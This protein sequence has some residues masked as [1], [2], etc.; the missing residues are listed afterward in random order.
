MVNKEGQ[1][2]NL[3]QII[4]T[5]LPPNQIQFGPTVGP[6]KIVTLAFCMSPTAASLKHETT[7]TG[8]SITPTTNNFKIE[9]R[10]D[11]D[12]SYENSTI[13]IEDDKIGD[14]CYENCILCDWSQGL[15][16][17]I[18]TKDYCNDDELEVRFLDSDNVNSGCN[19]QHR[20]CI[21]KDGKWK[22]CERQC[23]SYGCENSVI[24]DC[25]TWECIETNEFKIGRIDCDKDK[26]TLE[27]E[28]NTMNQQLDVYVYL[29]EEPSGKIYYSGSDTISDGFKG[30]KDVSIDKIASCPSG[31]ELN[32]LINVYD[33]DLNRVYT[34][35]GKGFKC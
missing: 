15:M 1:P 2:L 21:Y 31:T 12:Q 26:C 33:E 34:I 9:L 19:A 8:S 25:N 6:G 27:I 30:L 23:S 4:I 18:D 11:Y 35:K 24:F 32:A 16:R 22:C 7:V 10:G 20:A 13:Y 28:K 17:N 5:D 3:N 29:I 14:A